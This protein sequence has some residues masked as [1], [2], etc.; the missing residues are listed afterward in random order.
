MFIKTEEDFYKY[1]N[2]VC[3]VKDNES[4]KQEPV[5]KVPKVE[6]ERKKD[7]E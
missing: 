7:K 5:Q 1:L 3:G 6:L 2:K 4:N